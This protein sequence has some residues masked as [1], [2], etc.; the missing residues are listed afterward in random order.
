M[1]TARINNLSRGRHGFHIHERGD[2]TDGCASTGGHYNP[3]NQR[4]GG[5]GDAVRKVGSLGNIYSR[6]YGSAWYA[7]IDRLAKLT[8][9]TSIIGRAIVVHADEDD[10][11]HPGGNAGA[12]FS[13]GS[14]EWASPPE[15]IKPY[16]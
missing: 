10:F 12:R 15:E 14:I 7:R 1:I 4:H 13:C 9:P 6:G 2:L 5:P 11:S 3:F 16:W 8:G